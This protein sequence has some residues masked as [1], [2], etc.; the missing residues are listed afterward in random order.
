[1]TTVKPVREWG[2]SA[3]PAIAIYLTLVM[4]NQAPKQHLC[5]VSTL[6]M[7]VHIDLMRTV[8]AQP[9]Q[10]FATVADILE[11]PLLIGSIRSIELLTPGRIREGTHLRETRHLFGRET[12][13]ELEVAQ[14][15]SPHRLR[16]LVKD[17]DIHFELDYVIDGIF[18][19][20]S[21]LLLTFTSRPKT[22]TGKAAHPFMSPFIEI[23]LR[24]ELEQDLLD[25]AKAI[26]TR[27]ALAGSKSMTSSKPR[28]GL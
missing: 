23:T 16:L 15:E 2:K 20:G 7:T 10:A 26:M 19:G 12:V 5:T 22:Q 3:R 25:L 6:G 1:M 28:R 11:W 27:S 13:Q 14:I 21:R 4:D 24:D 17:P 18:G 9:A 8:A